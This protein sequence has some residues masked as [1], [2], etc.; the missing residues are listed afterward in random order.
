MLEILVFYMVVS[1]IED[2][3][4]RIKIIILDWYSWGIFR[5]F[6]R[7][8]ICRGKKKNFSN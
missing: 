4:V 5:F 2:N 7:F 3:I 1:F 6:F 8:Y